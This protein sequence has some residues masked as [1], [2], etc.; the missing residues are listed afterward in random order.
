MSFTKQD[1]ERLYL[2][3]MDIM[4]DLE[5][6]RQTYNNNSAMEKCQKLKQVIEWL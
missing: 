2:L 5:K 3:I 6:C 4:E 1:K